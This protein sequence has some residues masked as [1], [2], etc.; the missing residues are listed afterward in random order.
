[1]EEQGKR[2][3]EE[4]KVITEALM[5]MIQ[6]EMC[7]EHQ[8]PALIM[9]DSNVTPNRLEVVKDMIEQ[10]RWTDVGGKAHWWGG[11]PNET[12]CQSREDASPSRIDGILATIEAVTMAP[13]VYVR[14][15]DNI[16]TRAAVGG[17]Q[18]KRG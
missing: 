17:H 9:G 1:M 8:R 15:D 11:K 7:Q 2:R 3:D 6:E 10:D 18:Q 13:K 4:A 12:T 16:P 14:K 5:Q